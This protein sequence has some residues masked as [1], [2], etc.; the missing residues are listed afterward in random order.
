MQHVRY[1]CRIWTLLC[2]LNIVVVVTGEAYTTQKEGSGWPIPL[3]TFGVIADPHANVIH[4]QPW[5]CDL[6][7]W[8]RE[9]KLAAS[10][11]GRKHAGV[12]K[13]VNE[14][15]EVLAGV[16]GITFSVNLGDLC[17]MDM[18]VNMPIVLDIWDKLPHP[19]HNLMGNHDLRG[20]N[21]R[22]GEP[23]KMRNRTQYEWLLKQWGLNEV[24]Y[25]SFSHGPFRFIVL[26]SMTLP[27]TGGGKMKDV[28]VQWLESQLT[29]ASNQNEE[30]IIFAHIPIGMGTNALR[31][32]LGKHDNILAIFHGHKHKGGY[33]F[34]ETGKHL[35][36]IQGMIETDINAFAY[37][38]I[39]IDRIEVIGFGRVPTR[40]Y[41]KTPKQIQRAKD[42][43]S[44]Q[45]LPLIEKY[46][47]EAAFDGA[48]VKSYISDLGSGKVNFNKHFD[49]P[50]DITQKGL[51]P[52]KQQQDIS[53][54][55]SR[56]VP[57]LKNITQRTLAPRVQTILDSGMSF[58]E[59]SGGSET[60][61]HGA[62]SQRVVTRPVETDDRVLTEDHHAVIASYSA[63]TLIT[64]LSVLLSL[65]FI[66]MWKSGLRSRKVAKH[67]TP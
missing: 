3:L 16:P 13:K 65:I 39:F 53:W 58:D 35:I 64:I 50:K 57:L 40:V 32:T 56:G 33:D 44:S 2:L 29:S 34:H 52:L 10:S 54:L 6:Q 17:D 12:L 14:S 19:H 25:Y 11:K 45:Y 41:F 22:F 27:P 24:F 62:S 30:V 23:A 37:I 42:R 47:T 15:V 26:D 48:V 28:Q 51:Q 9:V 38:N 36:T 31:H 43:P 8:K 5:W 18:L 60:D 20:E 7:C 61:S 67:P 49:I 59:V 4:R 63:S 55:K 46:K 1:E 21:D 66:W